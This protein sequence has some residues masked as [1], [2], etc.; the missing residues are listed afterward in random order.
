MISYIYILIF[1]KEFKSNY[2]IEDDYLASIVSIRAI[3][4]SRS[5]YICLE[6]VTSKGLRI[7]FT[8]YNRTFNQFLNDQQ[9]ARAEILKIIHVRHPPNEMYGL[10]KNVNLYCSYGD[11][12]KLCFFDPF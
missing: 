3:P 2:A 11:N 1:Q 4:A 12:G 6:A 5:H 8:V 10:N 7:Y 9:G